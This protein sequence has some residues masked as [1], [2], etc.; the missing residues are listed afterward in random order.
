MT[1]LPSSPGVSARMSRQRSRDTGIELAV[2]RL[3]YAQGF[4]Y[5]VNLPVAGMRR[6]TIDIA[7]TKKRVA[8]FLDGCF[9]H[10]CPEHATQ[11]KANDTWWTEKLERNKARDTET[12]SVLE[13]AGWTVLRFW[14]HEDAVTVAATVSRHLREH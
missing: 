3:L 12:A 1:I 8:I 13:E 9:W 2:R 6:R 11:P 7:F 14:E 4:R 5:R 10:S